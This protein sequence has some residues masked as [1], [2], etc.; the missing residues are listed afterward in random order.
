MMGDCGLLVVYGEEIDLEINRKVQAA[1]YALEQMQLP[2]I[3]E[4]VPAYCSLLLVYDPLAVKSDA[5][6]SAVT[7]IEAQLT[8]INIPSPET[9]EIPVCYGDEYGPDLA[10]VATVNGL[11]EKE[12]ARLHSEPCYP[13][14][15]LGFTPG[16]PFLG[17]LSEKLHTPRLEQPRISVPAGS[18][19]IANNQTG[20]YPI[21]SPGGW[22][23]IG[24]TPLKLF[25]PR[26]AKPFLLKAGNFLRFQPISPQE[27][28]RLAKEE[29]T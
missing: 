20:I 3:T 1:K 11:S 22:Q 23:L 26:R 24:R 27:F 14:Y 28:N 21:E 4:I 13:I 10:H 25:E 15:M 8:Q 16:F 12:V 29:A 18:V 7:D 17:G 2:G 6:K 5:L 19:G 9:I